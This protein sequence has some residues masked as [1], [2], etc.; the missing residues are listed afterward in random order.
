MDYANATLPNSS[1]GFALMELEMGYLPRTSFDQD[2]LTEPLT[3]R[4]R[5][6]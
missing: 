1:A 4:E 3:V 2:R 5:L 6:S